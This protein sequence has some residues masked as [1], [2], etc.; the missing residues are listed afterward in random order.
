MHS[1]SVAPPLYGPVSFS[2]DGKCVALRSST[3]S[4]LHLWDISAAKEKFRLSLD[5][6]NNANC[7]SF[8]NDG[9]F[10]AVGHQWSGVSVWDL[11]KER[12][13]W[14]VKGVRGTAAHACLVALSPDGN[15]VASTD[16]TETN[17]IATKI[18]LWELPTGKVLHRLSC[19]AVD[20][21]IFSPDSKTLACGDGNDAIIL[22]EVTTGM[23]RQRFVAPGTFIGSIACSANGRTLASTDYLVNPLRGVIRIWDAFTGSEIQQMH[24]D[25]GAFTSVFFSPG[26]KTI[27]S[28]GTD[29]TILLWSVKQANQRA[30][31]G[32]DKTPSEMAELDSDSLLSLWHDLANDDSSKAYRAMGRL[33]MSGN[34]TA[35]FLKQKIVPALPNDQRQTQQWIADL[36]S[37][38]FETRAKAMD[39]LRKLGD[40]AEP[41]LAKGLASN[42]PLEAK[43]RMQE[44]LDEIRRPVT[45][46]D[47]LQTLRAIEVLE[48]IGS[49]NAKEVLRTLAAG[50]PEARVTREAKASLDRLAKRP[51]ETR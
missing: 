8:S 33:L 29:T 38:N 11:T 46:P 9:Q 40:L 5:R 3:D 28:T 14:A 2:Y 45:T 20:S 35:A 30:H 37:K 39:G 23:Q 43:R 6:D 36:E 41:V 16:P 21:F 15:T 32:P 50:A 10:L 34:K 7:A 31:V 12:R 13:L 42:P 1:Y 17:R 25:E 44:L 19:R 26:G 4:D 49:P 47:K 51:R 18:V 22:W 48:H 27:A 24:G